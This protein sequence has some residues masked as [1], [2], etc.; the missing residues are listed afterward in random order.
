V[1]V[2]VGVDIVRIARI[3]AALERFGDRFARRLTTE[4]EY[5]AYRESPRPAHFLAKRFAAKEAAAKAL[6]T[7]FR[8]GLSLRHIGVTRDPLGRPGLAF[9]DRAWRLAQGRGVIGSHLSLADE[10]DYAIA[11]VVLTGVAA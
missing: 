9:H 4:E 7:G 1:I 3:D 2:G 8:F 11:Y 10:D 6:G 5:R